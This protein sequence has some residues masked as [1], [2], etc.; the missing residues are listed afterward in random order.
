MEGTSYLGGDGS[1]RVG[2][3]TTPLS[4]ILLLLLK[5]EGVPGLGKAA[6]QVP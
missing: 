4:F 3:E 5:L 1:I 6:C 2:W